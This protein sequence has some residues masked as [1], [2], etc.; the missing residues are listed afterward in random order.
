MDFLVLNIG[1]THTQVAACDAAGP[2]PAERLATVALG[3]ADAPAGLLAAHPALPLVAACVVP[4][5]AQRLRR[6]WPDRRLILVEAALVQELD[7]SLVARWLGADRL[8][9]AVAGLEFARPPFIV[10]DAG[11]AVTLTVVDGARCIR[12]GAI[13]PGRRL[14]H[15]AL[16]TGTAQLPDVDLA[17]ALPS[18]FGAETADAIRAGIDLGI[19]GAVR[20]LVERTHAGLEAACPVLVTGGDAGHF[21]SALPDLTPVPPDFTLRGVARVGRTALGAAPGGPL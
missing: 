19:T 12:G 20:L 21:L 17:T 6:A 9:N 11:T 2:G 15:R 1:N 13:L 5:A 18:P 3:H 10:L 16:H 8:A 4:A 7:V 14:Q